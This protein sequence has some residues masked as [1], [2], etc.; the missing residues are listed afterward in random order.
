MSL[1]PAKPGQILT[2]A[3]KHGRMLKIAE[4]VKFISGMGTAFYNHPFIKEAVREAQ[5][6]EEEKIRERIVCGGNRLS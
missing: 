1:N 2:D 5:R 4:Q 6:I 3:E